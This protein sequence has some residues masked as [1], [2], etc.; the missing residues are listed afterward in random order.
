L[1]TLLRAVEVVRISETARAALV[2]PPRIHRHRYFG[3][4]APHSRSRG[5]LTALAVAAATTT[6][7]SPP[8]RPAA[9][10]THRRAARY[11]WA[12]RLDR[13]YEDQT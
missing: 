11:A 12:L 9:E 6:Q 3:V 7:T 13:I 10:P 8:N 2:P 1:S 4:L 5:A